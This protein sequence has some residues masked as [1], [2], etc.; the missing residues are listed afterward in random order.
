MGYS[1]TSQDPFREYSD[2]HGSTV[3]LGTDTAFWIYQP[4]V[5][6]KQLWTVTFSQSD[7]DPFSVNINTIQDI[8]ISGDKAVIHYLDQADPKIAHVAYLKFAS[9][10]QA[11]LIYH[12]EISKIDDTL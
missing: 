9:N 4:F 3:I 11:K 10:S 6:E 2:F 7:L 5:N 12:T 8:A 1:T